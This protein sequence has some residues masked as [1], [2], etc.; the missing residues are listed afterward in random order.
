MQ[1][2][3]HF[4]RNLFARQHA[5]KALDE[6]LRFY[7]DSITEQKMADGMS[8]EEARRSARLEAGSMTSLKEAVREARAG[9]LTERFVQDL[10]YAGRALRH[11]PGFTVLVCLILALGIGANT[12]VFGVLNGV[13]L[14][15]LPFADSDRLITIDGY[16]MRI[17]GALVRLREQSRTA[18]YAAYSQ[19]T[20]VNVNGL[21]DPL[22]VSA[23]SVSGNFFSVLGVTP[24]LGRSFQLQEEERGRGQV[25]ILS[26]AFAQAHFGPDSNVIGKYITVN[27]TPRLIIGVMPP[28]FRFPASSVAMW[29]PIAINPGNIGQYWWMRDLAMVGRLRP[30]ISLQQAQAD[31]CIVALRIKEA[32]PYKL[33]PDWG[34]DAHVLNLR[35]ALVTEVRPR[36]L[37]IFCSAVLV[38]LIACANFSNLLLLRAAARQREISVRIALGAGRWRVVQQL[39]TETVLL[40]IGGTSGAVALAWIGTV[41]LKSYLPP[42]TPRLHE[43]GTDT[44]TFL[45]VATLFAV[46]TFGFGLLPAIRAYKSDVQESLKSSGRSATEARQRTF[47]LSGFVVFQIAVSVV[48]IVSSS[49]LTQTVWRLSHVPPGFRADHL[50]TF[51]LTPNPSLWPAR[52]TAFYEAVIQRVRSIPG[53][54]E[55]AAVN[56]FP[57]SGD[58][59]GFAAEFE[60]HPVL[61]GHSAP[62]VWSSIATP[63]YTQTMRIPLLQGRAF[64]DS[65]HEHSEQVAM[66]SAKTAQRYW[67]G[68]T[69]LGKHVRAVSSKEWHTVVGV[70]GDLKTTTLG[71]DLSWQEG[72]VYL[73]YRQ[74]F[75][76]SPQPNM[77]IVVRTT[78]DPLRIA[79][80]IQRVVREINS[81]VPVTHI[82]TAEETLAS[83]LAEPRSTMSLLL[84]LAGLGLVLSCV[85]IYGVVAYG[86]SQR[87]REIGVRVALGAQP[88]NVC[89]LVVKRVSILAVVGFWCGVGGALGAS[90]FLQSQLFQ[91]KPNDLRTYA[92]AALIVAVTVFVACFG[93]IRRAVRLDPIVALRE[94]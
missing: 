14:K 73:P 76:G 30:G 66:V 67:P 58:F 74:G 32:F 85:G 36:L 59:S 25:V 5:E 1:R 12:A 43:V 20:E 19:G 34:M 75:D 64:T 38:F 13:L 62:A 44:Q 4:L 42:G 47:L 86:V 24:M 35:E 33:W 80:V 77:T 90:R 84:A 61:P 9:S 11:N 45:F 27:E 57:L 87:I 50:L 3:K 94:E 92:A 79:S 56:V 69:P 2:I 91:V 31:L 22:R 41:S 93:P 68:E 21:G 7:L 17:Q 82:E 16:S 52:S 83:S 8:S 88:W 23:S 53:A 71:P 51:R 40:A 70:V 54:A 60:G 55:A 37:L 81:D 48:V 18:E 89:L 49:L 78:S 28:G 6:E 10:R 46:S 39:M 15:P 65:D 29:L 63:N 26:H 72:E